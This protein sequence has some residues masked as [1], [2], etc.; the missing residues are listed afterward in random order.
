L[1]SFKHAATLQHTLPHNPH[2]LLIRIDKKAGHGAGKS[3]DQRYAME[4][5]ASYISSIDYMY[6]IKEAADKWGFVV[7]SLGLKRVAQ[8]RL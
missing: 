3:T 7:Q 1:H 6:R 4:S 2:P 8:D 5:R